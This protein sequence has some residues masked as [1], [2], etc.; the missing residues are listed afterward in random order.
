M[1]SFSFVK[2][3]KK[4]YHPPHP[5]DPLA[6]S[7]DWRNNS[8]LLWV[9][10]LLLFKKVLLEYSFF[11]MLVISTVQ[12]SESAICVHL[13][14]LLWIP[15]HLGHHRKKKEN[16]HRHTNELNILEVGL[17]PFFSLS[18][19]RASP[20]LQEDSELVLRDAIRLASG[21]RQPWTWLLSTSGITR[22]LV[23]CRRGAHESCSF[24]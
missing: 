20:C 4:K 13:S 11:T 10:F 8:E 1:L 2:Q 16:A 6:T 19:F 17:L 14:P 24:L 21:M 22:T 9:Y 15:S 23:P 7:Q 18:A 12:Q 3:K 5:Q